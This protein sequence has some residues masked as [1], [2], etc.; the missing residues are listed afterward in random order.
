MKLVGLPLFV[1]GRERLER[2]DHDGEL[3]VVSELSALPH[4]AEQR[5]E[6]GAL[7]EPKDAVERSGLLECLLNQ[8]QAC[9]ESLV[10]VSLVV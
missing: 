9:V 4:Q 2:R 6:G 7:R 5:G 3:E 10:A 8:L 1:F